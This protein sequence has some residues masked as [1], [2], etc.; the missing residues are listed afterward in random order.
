MTT[1]HRPVARTWSCLACG[2]PWPCQTRRGHLL[3]Q[4]TGAP[5]S[6]ALVLGSAMIEAAAD[7]RGVPAGELPDQF[8]GWLPGYRHH[9]H[10]S[11]AGRAGALLSG[12][13]PG[14]GIDAL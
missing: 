9:G 10:G 4:Y 5:A 12:P 11:A 8:I 3:G 1:L 14:L 2:G 6:L 7:L 13:Y